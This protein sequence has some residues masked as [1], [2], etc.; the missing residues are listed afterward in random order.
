M[1]FLK[2]IRALFKPAPR[3]RPRECRERVLA[4]TAVLVDVREP[5]EW[6]RGVAEQAVRLSFTDLTGKRE[7]WTP[8]LAGVQERE[9]I[10]YCAAGGRAMVAAGMLAEEGFRAVN[11]GSLSDWA[12]AGWPIVKP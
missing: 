7:A 6:E 5:S 4:G 8:F 2:V 11:G 3:V 12:K 1:K 9:L 10:L